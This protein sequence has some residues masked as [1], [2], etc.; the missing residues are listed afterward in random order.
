LISVPIAFLVTYVVSLATRNR[1]P[2]GVSRVMLRMHAPD[3]LGF[4]DDRA[5]RRVGE[6]RHATEGG[7][8][9]R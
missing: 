5:L 4:I 8:H 1:I 6:S 7:R 2:S 9:R 3:R